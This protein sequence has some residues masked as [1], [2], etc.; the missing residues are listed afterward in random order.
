LGRLDSLTGS[1]TLRQGFPIMGREG[2]DL[3]SMIA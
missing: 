3:I 2:L 1:L